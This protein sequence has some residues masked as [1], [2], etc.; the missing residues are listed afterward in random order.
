MKFLK[1]VAI[2]TLQVALLIGISFLGDLLAKILHIPLPG[3]LVGMFILLGLL[4][5]KVIKME[6]IELGAAV[7]IGDLLLFFVPSAIGI[8]Q[9]QDLFGKTGALLIAIVI[10]SILMV[11]GTVIVSSNCW[12]KFKRKGEEI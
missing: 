4:F 12:M 11:I 2:V 6:W 8:V 7:L 9:H 1:R 5:T 10:V 3:S